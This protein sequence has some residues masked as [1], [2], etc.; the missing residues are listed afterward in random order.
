MM[1]QIASALYIGWRMLLTNK[2]L[3]L[4][5]GLLTCNPEL[6]SAMVA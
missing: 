2:V 4:D 1:L 3:M 5:N 6:L